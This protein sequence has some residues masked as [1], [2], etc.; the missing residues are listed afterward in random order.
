MPV[1]SAFGSGLYY[2]LAG[3]LHVF[4][5]GGGVNE[6]FAI[7]TDLIIFVVLVTQLFV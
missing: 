1:V 7:Y 3:L 2:G 4:K 5:K 6:R